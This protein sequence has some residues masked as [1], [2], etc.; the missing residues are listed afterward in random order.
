MLIFRL[1]IGSV[2]LIIVVGC[3]WGL[4]HFLGERIDRE[5][6]EVYEDHKGG[7]ET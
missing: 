7:D 2:C 3:L 1:I 5:I 4:G 6:G